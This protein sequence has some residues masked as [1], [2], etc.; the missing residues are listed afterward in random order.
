MLCLDGIPLYL[1]LL[2]INAKESGFVFVLCLRLT[3]LDLFLPLRIPKRGIRDVG[4]FFFWS[5]FSV[6]H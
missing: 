1:L 5:R 6:F 4:V 2:S 3:T